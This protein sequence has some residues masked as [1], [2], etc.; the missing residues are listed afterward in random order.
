MPADL[1]HAL[2]DPRPLIEARAFDPR[3]TERVGV[4]KGDGEGVDGILAA[5]TAWF[6]ILDCV[7]HL[8]LLRTDDASVG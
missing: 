8:S 3:E 7:M 4:R 2:F 6:G 1:V 5:E